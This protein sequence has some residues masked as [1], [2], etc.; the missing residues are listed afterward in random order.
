MGDLRYVSRAPYK[1]TATDHRRQD[2]G[3]PQ[4]APRVPC[5]PSARLVDPSPWLPCS[6]PYENTG[7]FSTAQNTLLWWWAAGMRTAP[8]APTTRLAAPAWRACCAGRQDHLRGQRVSGGAIFETSLHAR[9]AAVPARLLDNL[10]LLRHTSSN[11]P[12]ASGSGGSQ[13][14]RQASSAWKRGSGRHMSCCGALA[15]KNGLDSCSSQSHILQAHVINAARRLLWK[16]ATH[17]QRATML[18]RFMQL[19]ARRHNILRPSSCCWCAC[20][21]CAVCWCVILVIG[22]AMVVAGNM[23]VRTCSG[24]DAHANRPRPSQ[25]PLHLF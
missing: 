3:M 2:G 4:M 12:R 10:L 17:A 18:R 19:V 25:V 1:R 5:R 9:S 22:A 24:Q 14:N 6:P 15:A 13:L 11:C 8:T 23:F 21:R 20:R 7:M 16:H